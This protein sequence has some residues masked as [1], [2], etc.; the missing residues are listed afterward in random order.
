MASRTAGVLTE[1]G[2]EQRLWAASSCRQAGHRS[3]PHGL[4]PLVSV[5]AFVF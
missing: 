4:C 2:A 1:R 5:S 3:L